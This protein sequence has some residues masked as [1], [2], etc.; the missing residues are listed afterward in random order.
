[1]SM[2]GLE[3]IDR[4]VQETN[5][6]LKELM[7]ALNR[8]DRRQVYSFLRATLH[9]VRDRVGVDNAAHLGAQLPTLV[10]GVYYEGWHPAGT[11]TKER[12]TEDFLEHVHR[13]LPNEHI[14]EVERGVKAVLQ[15]LHHRLD[16]GEV[17]KIATMFPK[18]VRALWPEG[19]REEAVARNR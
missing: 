6:W 11:P 5:L 7:D 1:M 4:T 13:E 12:H 19:V 18:E 9:A 14:G 3:N 16:P 15:L 8:E 10:R 2:T 17:V